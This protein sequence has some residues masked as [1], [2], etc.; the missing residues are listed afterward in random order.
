MARDFQRGAEEGVKNYGRR[1]AL[2]FP[3]LRPSNVDL[4]NVQVSIFFLED[5]LIGKKEFS[6]WIVVPTGE[7]E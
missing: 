6:Y 1:D 7:L 2:R 5:N 3:A 4:N